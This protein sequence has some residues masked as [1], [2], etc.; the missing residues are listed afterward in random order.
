M[1]EMQRRGLC[2]FTFANAGDKVYS[3]TLKQWGVVHKADFLNSYMFIR[4]DDGLDVQF[5]Y[6]GYRSKGN[7]TSK[8]TQ[9]LFWDE[10]CTAKPMMPQ[11]ILER[12]EIISTTKFTFGGYK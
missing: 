3:A 2:P 1:D 7:Y 12:N 10:Q 6:S 5:T 4:F 9:E 11:S 8:D